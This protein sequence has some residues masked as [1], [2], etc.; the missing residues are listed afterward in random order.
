MHSKDDRK[1]KRMRV[2]ET[3]M[4]CRKTDM[5]GI[6]KAFFILEKARTNRKTFC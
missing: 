5:S 1:Q 4:E 2:T 6:A 3:L